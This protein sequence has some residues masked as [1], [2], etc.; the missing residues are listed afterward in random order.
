MTAP[1][2]PLIGSQC[3]GYRIESFIGAGGM[4]RVYQARHELLGREAALKVLAT[5]LGSDEDYINR[6]I[7]EAKLAASLHHPH[8]VEVYDFGLSDQG[9]Y[10]AMEFV[11]GASLGQLLRTQPRL[12]EADVLKIAGQSLA[13]L[14][15]AHDAGVIHRDIKPDNLLIQK[16]GSVKV[17]DLGLAKTVTTEGDTSLTLSGMVLGTPSYMSP[18]Q[19]RG[20]KEVDGRS[21]LYS[22]GATLFHCATGQL[23][24][25]GATPM[26]VMQKQLEEPPPNPRQFAPALSEATASFILRLMQKNPDYRYVNAREAAEVVGNI[27]KQGIQPTPRITEL[28]IEDEPS[29]LQKLTPYAVVVLVVAALGAGGFWWWNA[30]QKVSAVPAGSQ[31][32]TRPR[33]VSQPPQDEPSAPPSNP[34]SPSKEEP[35]P[36]APK[37]TEQATPPPPTLPAAGGHFPKREIGMGVF[38]VTGASKDGALRGVAGQPGELTHSVMLQLTREQ[39]VFLHFSFDAIRK[40]LEAQLGPKAEIRRASLVVTAAAKDTTSSTKIKLLRLER[41]LA[42][43]YEPASA[44]LAGSPVSVNSSSFQITFEI[45][46]EILRIAAGGANFGW[47]LT[48]EGEGEILVPSGLHPQQDLLPSL[49]FAVR[50]QKEA[51]ATEKP[52]D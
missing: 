32:V 7:R 19:V 23:P 31:P 15:Y 21:D 11:R 46:E 14:G 24:F 44:P 18:E 9:Y 13:A 16:D 52:H 4:G 17:T 47:V 39:Q 40:E 1:V 35:P 33:P 30:Q 27:R 29:L 2:D 45:S 26:V 50:V 48:L 8:L 49:T 10:L 36:P 28:H 3:G 51:P 43:A 42:E 22:L 12:E 37:T 6:F 25:K 38:R 20:E 34:V 41:D 5:R